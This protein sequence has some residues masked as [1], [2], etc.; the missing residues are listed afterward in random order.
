MAKKLF[1]LLA[2]AGLGVE[3]SYAGTYELD[4][5]HS[6]INFSVTHL[7]VSQVPGSFN[8]YDARINFDPNDL[9][10]SSIAATVRVAS[11]NTNHTERDKHL[12]SADFFDVE[13][14]PKI[15]FKTSAITGTGDQYV[16]TGDLTMRG[17]TRKVSIPVTIMG[18]VQSPFGFEALG[19]TGQFKLNRKDYGLTWNKSMDN[20][21]VVLGDEVDVAVSLEAHSPAAQ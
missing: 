16:L 15:T 4:K 11:I 6:A 3:L 21:G 17:V 18:P 9:A 13:K 10:G 1:L 20:G 12:K 2:V 8:D 19:I 7:M 14:F 5:A